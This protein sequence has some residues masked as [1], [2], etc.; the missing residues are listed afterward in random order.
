MKPYSPSLETVRDRL[1]KVRSDPS[2]KN[3]FPKELWNDIFSLVKDYSF[4]LVSR[5]LNLGRRFLARKIEES[6]P[7]KT[8]KPEFREVTFKPPSNDQVI[9]EMTRSDLKARIEG[10][11]SCINSLISLF[12]GE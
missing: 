4:D 6:L 3:K 8:S 7:K 10:P 12:K 2:Y 1:A 11:V 5:E 9:I